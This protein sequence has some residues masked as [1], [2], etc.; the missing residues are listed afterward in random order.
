MSLRPFRLPSDLQLMVELLPQC[1]QYPEN[2]EWGVQKD[3]EQ[4]FL[5]LVKTARRLWPLFSVLFKV[6]PSLRDVLHGFIWEE[7]GKPVGI[8]NISR[9]GTSEDWIIANVGVLPEYRRHGIARKLVE[10]AIG[11]AREHRAANVLLDVIAGN[12]PAY[13][14]YVALGFSHFSSSVEMLLD[15]SSA[16]RPDCPLPDGYRVTRL[17]PSHWQPFYQ[18]AQRVT[19]AEVQAYRPV[20]VHQFRPS[21]GLSLAGGLLNTFSGVREV[22]LVVEEGRERQVVAT[23]NLSAHTRGI[24]MNDCRMTLDPARL[25]LA[26]PLVAATLAIF[27]ELSPRNRIQCRIEAWQPKLIDAALASGFQRKLVGDRLG[28]KLS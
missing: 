2:P 19:P 7:S 5:D 25:P 16:A 17:S 15:P 22:G 13:D 21:L 1:F 18:L 26:S 23:A 9:D 8:V 24:G 28:L 20:T 14:L 10:A 12:T 11:L 27:R 3:E 6:S 4:N